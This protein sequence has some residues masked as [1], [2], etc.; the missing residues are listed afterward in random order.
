MIAELDA[1][2][3]L[4]AAPGVKTA[5]RC[6]RLAQA[7]WAKHSVRVRA[8]MIG[9][10]RSLIAD[11]ALSLARTTA[12]VG[13]RTAA[14]KMA[15][16]V[17][18]LLET[19]RFLQKNAARV[20]AAK[21]F[22]RRGRPLW[23]PGHSFVVERRPFGVILI[24]APANYPLFLPAAQMLHALAAGNAI[25]LKPAP[26]ASAP[27]QQ[28]LEQIIARSQ[29]SPQ[30]VQILP[31]SPA[32]ARAVVREGVD[33]VVFTG[34]SDN[35]RDFLAELAA[36]NTPSVM[37]LSGADIVFVRADADLKLA[38]KAI[39][40]GRRLNG[41]NTCMA[42]ASIVAHTSIATLLREELRRLNAETDAIIVVRDDA[43][44]LEIAHADQHGLGASIFSRDESAARV[45]ARQLRTGF[46][47][48]N[49][50]IVPTADPRFPFGGVRK[51]GFGVTRGEE[52]LLE[53]T[54]PQAIATRRTRFLPH[55]ELAQPGDA[56]LFAAFARFTHSNGFANRLRALL[57][58]VRLS[59]IR[60]GKS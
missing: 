5:V 19:A 16:E 8:Q 49:D 54:Y 42:P 40:F 31:E 28:F 53:M 35:G 41:G 11:H 10:L 17:L 3:M 59:R 47:T 44:A 34:S 45:W 15:S 58:I 33:K 60:K 2:N 51:S 52:G 14:E 48:I 23:L 50:L 18:P 6:A 57:A 32:V 12:A 20:L 29:I 26:S 56:D 4:E 55:L 27:L 43:Q 30:L 25:L 24:V 21:R 7:E 46:V 37:E 39:A 13:N 36:Q 38:A 1:E 22:G 9:A